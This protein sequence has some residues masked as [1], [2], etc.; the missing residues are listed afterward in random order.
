MS[1]GDRWRWAGR[2]HPASLAVVAALDAGLAEL[3][4]WGGR[5]LD[6]SAEL[7]DVVQ[8]LALAQLEAQAATAAEG[9]PAVLRDA[10]RRVR[11]DTWQ[12]RRTRG[13]A[14]RVPWY[15]EHARYLVGPDAGLAATEELGWDDVVRILGWQDG[16]ALWL[17]AV[18]GWSLSEIGAWQ[19]VTKQQVWRR[20]RRALAQLRARL[21]PPRAG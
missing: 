9:G 13:R 17:W 10:Q 8:M 1:A 11:R 6:A 5:D 2:L 3:L 21:A 4:H 7:D 15:P 12:V 20:L 14:H 18:E 16:L 19:A